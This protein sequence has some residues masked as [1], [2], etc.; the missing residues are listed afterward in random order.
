MEG[1]AVGK[2]VIATRTMSSGEDLG[3]IAGIVWTGQEL[4]DFVQSL[5]SARAHL[6]ELQNSAREQAAHLQEF[7]I[8]STV[9]QIADRVTSAWQRGRMP[10]RPIA[11]PSA[12]AH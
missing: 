11:R 2:P 8:A 7:A 4:D 10:S 12:S 6:T 9:P 5:V 3:G 1:L